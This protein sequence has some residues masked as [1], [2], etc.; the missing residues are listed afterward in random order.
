VIAAK[1]IVLLC[2]VGFPHDYFLDLVWF[3]CC[4]LYCRTFVKAVTKLYAAV[5]SNLY[6]SV[7]LS[8]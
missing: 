4:A 3:V 7:S 8:E 1:C 5:K 6:K 2:C